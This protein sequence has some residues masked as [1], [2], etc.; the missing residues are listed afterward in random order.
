VAGRTVRG[1]RV[2][3]PI[4]CLVAGFG[5]AASA[6]VARGTDLRSPQLA[7]RPGLTALVNA[8][9]RRV[10]DY[11]ATAADLQ[12]GVSAATAAAARE[13][14]AVAAAQAES[15]PLRSPMGL[16]AVSGPGMLV[17]LDDAHSVPAGI[18]PAELNQLVI[19]QSDLQAVV[20]AL[21]A[22][23]AEAM[24]IAGQRIIPTSA[25]RCVG[26]TLLLNGRVFSPPFRVAAVGAPGTMQ[27]ALDKSPGV[28][29]VRQ[30]AGFYGLGY[31]VSQRERLDLPAYAGAV[32]LSYA[33][34][35]SK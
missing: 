26:N 3:V 29:V 8:A 33:K 18:S 30:A 23:G 19:H 1:W 13:N 4:I 25:V 2:L 27:T 28:A 5:F 31:T 15:A 9:E 16:T 22:G 35:G 10:A 32:G 34:A 24:T 17:V 20:N 11:S 21:W 6:R 7:D 12:A 14:S